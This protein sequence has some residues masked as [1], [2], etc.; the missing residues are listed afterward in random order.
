MNLFPGP[1]DALLADFADILVSSLVSLA[2][3]VAQFGKLHQ[4]K[5]PVAAVL[6]VELHHRMGSGGGAGEEVKNDI[7]IIFGSYIFYQ[8]FNI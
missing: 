3:F 5:A 4:N 2:L 8:L 7:T 6:G 1:S